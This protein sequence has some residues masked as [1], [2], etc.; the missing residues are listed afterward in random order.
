MAE[1]AVRNNTGVITSVL[2]I[3]RTI[4]KPSIFGIITN[5]ITGNPNLKPADEYQFQTVYVMKSK[6]Q[7]IGW[8][9]YT[10]NYF[11]QSPYQRHDRLAISYQSQNFN[12]QQQG[13]LQA[14]VPFKVSQLLDSRFTLMGVWQRE[15][16]DHFYDISFDRHVFYVMANLNNNITLST[17]PDITLSVDGMIRSK[18]IQATYDLP[19]SGD[20]NLSARWLFMKKHAIVRVFCNDIF[21]TSVIN[22]RINYDRQDLGMDFSC[23]R[24]FGVSFTYK[25]GGYKEKKNQAIDTSRFKQ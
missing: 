3:L 8:F 23:Y 18:A 21:Q 1:R 4:S 14:I 5:E 20:V 12:F 11:V 22:S 16:D 13:G 19:A 17:S 9:N 6:Y 25:F 10:N 2:R 24:E 15:K 7:L